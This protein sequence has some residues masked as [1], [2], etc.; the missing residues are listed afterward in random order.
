MKT[1]MTTG[2]HEEAP[3]SKPFLENGSITLSA[4][5]LHSPT[6]EQIRQRAIEIHKARGGGSGH[7]LDDWLQAER[8]FLAEQE[9]PA[10]PANEREGPTT[11][12][13]RCFSQQ[14]IESHI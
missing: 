6:P 3:D 14:E 4:R 2:K 7:E 1:K 11:G 10:G 13:S 8:E 5:K 12:A 9:Y